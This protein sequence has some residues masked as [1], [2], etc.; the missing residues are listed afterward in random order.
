VNPLAVLGTERVSQVTSVT[1]IAEA[2]ISGVIKT[3]SSIIN[4]ILFLVAK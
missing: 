1:G 4:C 2:A 3:I